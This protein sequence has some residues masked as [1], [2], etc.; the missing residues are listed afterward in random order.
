MIYSIQMNYKV[1]FTSTVEANDEGEA[2]TKAREMA[3]NADI[4]D[5]NFVEELESQ[6]VQQLNSPRQRRENFAVLND[7]ELFDLDEAPRPIG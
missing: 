1:Q 4:S 7:D 6:I 3:E 5:F 2:L